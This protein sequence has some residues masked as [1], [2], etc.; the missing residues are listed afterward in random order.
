MRKTTR[1][2]VCV[3]YVNRREGRVYGCFILN[4]TD[5]CILKDRW[6]RGEEAVASLTGGRDDVQ[7]GNEEDGEKGKRTRRRGA[8]DENRQDER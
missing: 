5:G 6:W 2:V 8:R 7:V 3:M 1:R 4:I